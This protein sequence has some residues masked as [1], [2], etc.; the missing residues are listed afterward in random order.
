MGTQ[1][2]VFRAH[3]GAGTVI[4]PSATI[5]GVQVPSGR[6]VPAGTKVT[7]QATADG[8]PKIT[9]SYALRDL[10]REF[11]RVNTTRADAHSA[12]TAAANA[13]SQD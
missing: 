12:R 2:L 5:I 8:L 9:Y 3:I 4:E 13:G 6:Y 1:A 11:V 10:N 7:D